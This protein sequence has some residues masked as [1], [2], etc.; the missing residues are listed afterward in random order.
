M[1]AQLVMYG[2][3]SYV[4]SVSGT[5]ACQFWVSPTDFN[6]AN[7]IGVDLAK[8]PSTVAPSSW[9]TGVDI[10]IATTGGYTTIGPT[11]NTGNHTGGAYISQAIWNAFPSG[12]G[13]WP[14]SPD[15]LYQYTAVLRA[16]DAANVTRY[17]GFKV[18]VIGAPFGTIVHVGF[19]PTGSATLPVGA[20]TRWI[21][22]A[23]A[24]TCDPPGGGFTTVAATSPINTIAAL[25][26]TSAGMTSQGIAGPKYPH[27]TGW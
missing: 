4:S 1:A 9:A 6:P 7:L 27:G 5:Y 3:D 2:V 18:K 22:L 14:P 12:R 23:D 15:A 8:N 13:H 20:T 25:Y 10:D 24:W 26:L 17:H 19:I 11:W 16:D 21:D